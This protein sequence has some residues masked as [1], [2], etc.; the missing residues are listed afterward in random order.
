MNLRRG[1]AKLLV[2]RPIVVADGFYQKRGS[3]GFVAALERHE[4]KGISLMG[5]SSNRARALLDPTVERCMIQIE[6]SRD[7]FHPKPKSSACRRVEQDTIVIPDCGSSF[8]AVCTISAN[9]RW[10]QRKSNGRV[11][12]KIGWRC[13]R[14]DHADPRNARATAAARSG[15]TSPVTRSTRSFPS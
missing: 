4:I 5:F 6:P 12:I 13:P 11:A 15:K 2:I 7:L 10:P 8:S 1:I 14:D 9:A 3:C